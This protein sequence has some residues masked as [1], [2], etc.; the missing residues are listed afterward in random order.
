MLHQAN[1]FANILMVAS[2]VT[3]LARP[4]FVLFPAP[5]TAGILL[6]TINWQFYFRQNG[7]VL[8]FRRSGIRV[9]RWGYHQQKILMHGKNAHLLYS[10]RLFS[11]S[12]SSW[13]LA[14]ADSHFTKEFPIENDTTRRGPENIFSFPSRSHRR[15]ERQEELKSQSKEKHRILLHVPFA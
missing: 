4:S 14:K 12:T 8:S 1:V 10:A 3:F 9:G 2:L 7:S 6:K 11:S 13:F 15:M 5:L